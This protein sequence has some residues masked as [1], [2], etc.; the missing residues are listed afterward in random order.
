MKKHQPYPF[1]EDETNGCSTANEPLA[2]YATEPYVIPEDTSYVCVENGI[3]H[4]TPDI[5]EEIAEV[6][7]G[8]VITMSEFNTMFSRWLAKVRWTLCCTQSS[9]S[10]SLRG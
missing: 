8:E 5:E 10:S 2:A 9:L 7:Q 4:V 3:L 6:E 1:A